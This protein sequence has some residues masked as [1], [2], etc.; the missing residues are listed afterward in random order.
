MS[1]LNANPGARAA[2]LRLEL[3]EHNHR[4]HVLDAPLIADSTYDALLRELQAIEAAH[5]ELV[6][7]DSPTQRVGAVVAGG[8]AEVH[9]DVPMLSLGNAFSDDDARDFF[10][11]IVEKLGRADV[12]FSVEPKIDG[13]AISLLYVDGVLQR[14]A[15]RGDGSKGEDV[16]HSVRTIASVPLRLLGSSWPKWLEV[17]GEVYMPR[18]A[19]EKFNERARERGERTLANPRNA[20]A[21]SIRQLDPKMAASRPLAFFAYALGRS[22]PE[23]T[24]QQHTDMLADFRAYGLPVCPEADR[25]LGLDGLRE[26]FQRIGARRDALPYDIDG[27]VYKVDA[28]A[29]QQL[30]GFVSRAPRW[31]IAH[32]FP[33]REEQ[34]VVE[35][36]DVQVGR[37]GA[38]TPVAR[39]KPV[40]VAG[41]IVTNATLH[42]ENEVRRKDVR[43]GDTVIVRRAGDVI[44]EVVSVVLEQRP[45][46][47][48]PFEMPTLCPECGSPL[49]R[50]EGEAAIR[51]SGGLFCPAQ[52]SESIHHFASR[53]AMDIEGLGPEAIDDLAEFGVLDSIAD[54]YRITADQLVQ[55]RKDAYVR[56]RGPRKF[57]PTEEPRKWAENLWDSIQHSKRQPLARLLFGLGVRMVG[58]QTAKGLAKAFGSLEL[59]RS[60]PWPIL[61]LAPEVGTESAKSLYEFFRESHNRQI[62]DD[63]V[64]LGISSEDEH[65]P[66]PGVL[67]SLSI[68]ELVAALKI[69]ALTP[70]RQALVLPKL[71]CVSDLLM[72]TE[73][74]MNQLGF[75]SSQVNSMNQFISDPASKELLREIDV[76]VTNLL[77]ARASAATIDD[78]PLEGMTFVLTG[79]LSGRTREQASEALEELGAKIASSVSKKTAAVIA[80]ADAGSKLDKARELGV[81]VL[82]EEAL[83]SLIVDPVGFWGKSR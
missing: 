42:N 37:T 23:A 75:K 15:T 14:A 76:S 3:A 5:P 53:L 49:V 48:T 2:A 45:P 46:N 10:E 25:A 55:C 21:G 82:D 16:T 52:R 33:A 19:F 43:V 28:L 63:L 12:A 30:L 62:V 6:V 64:D 13:L 38:I 44:P 7:P 69:S 18:A 60:L 79:A 83:E 47:S 67:A 35:A 61:S 31:A 4:Y 71:T 1:L 22:E 80:G 50:V 27:V 78:Q 20:A 32:K 11:R 29:A 34:T 65:T 51:C 36:I 72:L 68:S 8:F 40:Q 41:V 39:L 81:R 17:R 26:Y 24:W 9:H 70:T 58:E 74:D 77:S 73:A 54:L 57:D 59:I 66:A 56:K